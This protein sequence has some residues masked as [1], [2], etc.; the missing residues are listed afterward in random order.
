VFGLHAA[1]VILITRVV[2]NWDSIAVGIGAFVA[3][4]VVS[5]FGLT[6]AAGIDGADDVT[7]ARARIIDR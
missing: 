7:E 6:A 1:F 2:D 3:L 4:N 5:F